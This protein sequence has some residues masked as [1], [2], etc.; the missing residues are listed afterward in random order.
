MKKLLSVLFIL[1]LGLSICSCSTSVKQEEKKKDEIISGMPNPI[2]SYDSLEEINSKAKTHIVIPS[3]IPV[4]DFRYTTINDE[5]AQVNFVLDEHKWTVRGSKITDQDIS[6]IHDKDNIFN[7]GEDNCFYL[8]DYY[9]DRIFTEGI[10]YSIVMDEANGYDIE[11]YSNYVFEMENALKRASD[12]NGIAGVYA[13]TTSHR[14]SMEI[15]KYDNTYE[16]TVRWPNSSNE[17]KQWYMA[18]TLEDKKI[19]YKG[20]DVAVYVYDENGDCEVVSGTSTTINNV[21]HFEIKDERL[22]WTGAGEEQCK[23]CV[24]E[25]I[26]F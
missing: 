12:P 11:K 13:D 1:L 15:N 26:P 6:G 3:S 5:T 4:S 18:G 16:I 25:K 17:E 24:F 8:T 20:E 23:E 9:I 7:E 10:Q 22:Y 14:A 21:G 19:T 2:I